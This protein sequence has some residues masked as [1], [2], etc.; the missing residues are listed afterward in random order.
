MYL[1]YLGTK[2]LFPVAFLSDGTEVRRQLNHHYRDAP[3]YV[4]PVGRHLPSR[5]ALRAMRAVHR[6][7]NRWTAQTHRP[8]LAGHRRPNPYCAL[9]GR[10]PDGREG[11]RRR[12]RDCY[13][14]ESFGSCSGAVSCP[15]NCRRRNRRAAPGLQYYSEEDRTH[16]SVFFLSVPKVGTRKAN[17]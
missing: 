1:Y 15:A 8:F 9:R 14:R 16:L 11:R 2:D 12:S 6:R 10:S 17:K 4:S 13:E 5:L 3:S 7:R